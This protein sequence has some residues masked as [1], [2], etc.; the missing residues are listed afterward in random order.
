M[1]KGIYIFM[2]LTAMCA[3]S[4]PDIDTVVRECTSMPVE[5][6]GATAFVAGEKMYVFAGRDNDGVLHNDLWAYTPATDGWEH[7]GETPLSPRVNASAC[8][9]NGK[10]YI[11]LG[12]RGKYGVDSCYLR[13]WWEYTPESGTWQALADYPNEYTDRATAF[14]GDGELFV[15]YGF[16]RN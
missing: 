16:C 6:A 12:F 8:V 3:C 15:G 14:A 2:F 4:R 5:R 1:K 13:D 7:L 11:G 9:Q 10:V